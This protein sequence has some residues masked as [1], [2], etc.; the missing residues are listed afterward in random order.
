M[1]RFLQRRTVALT[2]VVALAGASGVALNAGVSAGSVAPARVPPGLDHFLC[3]AASPKN[4]VAIP[5]SVVLKNQFNRAGFKVAPLQSP[6]QHC[7]PVKKTV[8]P[9]V[10]PINNPDA[11]LLCYPVETPTQPP[12]LVKVSNQFGVAD[13]KTGSP[14]GLCLPTWK[15]LSGPPNIQPNQPP[16]LDHFT[17][18]PVQYADATRFKHPTNV[19]VQDQF[20]TAPVKVTIGEPV[21]LCLPTT[22]IVGHAVFKAANP[23]AHLL[24]FQV[25][26]TPHPPFV[27]DENQFGTDQILLQDTTVLCLPSYKAIIPG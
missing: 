17:C 25:S 24:C 19:K 18:Y 21:R 16:G 4:G 22:K 8:G 10:Y 14:Q 15:S 27:Y 13:L 2:V 7:N 1:S 20:T 6:L 9:H 11:H 12:R 5:P 26:K 3:Y 23:K